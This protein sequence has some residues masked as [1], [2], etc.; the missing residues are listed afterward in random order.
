MLGFLDTDVS[1]RFV[2]EVSDP[3][4]LAHL[5]I[6]NLDE[7]PRAPDRVQPAS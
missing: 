2:G 6:A 1:G 5:G 4:P 3:I 7:V